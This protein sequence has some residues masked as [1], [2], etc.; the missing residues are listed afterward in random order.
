VRTVPEDRAGQAT[1]AGDALPALGPHELLE[2]IG[3]GGMGVVFRARDVVLGRLVALK[4]IRSGALA[5]PEEVERFYREARAAARLR[6]P[7]V[8]PIHGLGLHGGQHCFTMD[9]IAGGSLARRLPDFQRDAR[10]AVALVEKVARAVHLAHGEGIIHRDL[11]PGNVLLDERG[12]PLVTDF[13]LAKY[14]DGVDVTRS[15][16]VLGTPAYMSPEQAAGQAAQVTP[17][18]DVWSLGVILYE[19]LAGQRP[20]RGQDTEEVKQRVL[21]AEPPRPGKLRRGLPRDL[22]VIVLKCLEKEPGRRYASAEALADDLR[23]WSDGR[24]IQ[25][26]PLPWPRRLGRALRRHPWRGA[27]AGLCLLLA[28]AVPLFFHFTDPDRPL[29]AL[30]GRLARGHEVTLIGDG[31]GPPW[32]EWVQGEGVF[33]PPPGQDDAF[34]ISALNRALLA[35]LR[36]PQQG[37]RLTAEVRHNEHSKGGEVGLFFGHSRYATGPGP[38]HSCCTWTFNDFERSV[39]DPGRGELAGAAS[40]AVRR[41]RESG[42]WS[43]EVVCARHFSPAGLAA[44]QLPPWRH[45]AVEVRPDTVQVFWE[46]QPAGSVAHA[47][48]GERLRALPIP[49]LNN[50]IAEGG[51]D[52]GPGFT[53]RGTV[54]LFVARGTASFRRVVVR[55]I[56]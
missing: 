7:N 26:R 25:T 20:F 3:E 18:S 39:W 9:L 38:S 21:T 50:P 54:G 12:E 49:R 28:G 16:Q 10:A 19:L 41:S 24:P 33:L 2:Q 32:K 40:L 51:P 5:G 45:L 11:K 34:T 47:R 42:G 31:G 13:G 22:E 4:M 15:G 14:P 53:P 46:N 44:G 35:L 56:P 30:Q 52:A 1:T 6:H 55:P 17:A 36:D 8:V 43:S 29:K 48:L 27:A 37:Y 23:N